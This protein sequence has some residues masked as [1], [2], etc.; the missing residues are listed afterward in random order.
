MIKNYLPNLKVATVTSVPIHP[1]TEPPFTVIYK[2]DRNEIKISE[3]KR[4]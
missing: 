1:I 3:E 4:K 2:P